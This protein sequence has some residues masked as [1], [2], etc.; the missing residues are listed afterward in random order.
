MT[1]VRAIIVDD[2]RLARERVRTL[3][4]NAGGVTI[5]AECAGGQEAVETIEAERPD[6]M[7]LDVQMPDLNGFEVLE[8]VGPD[9]LPAVVFV[10]AYDEYALRAFEV[11]A[12]DYLLK[13]IDPGRFAAALAHALEAVRARGQPQADRR[14][15]DLL[16]ALGER[17]QRLD[18]LVV[19]SQGK[20]FFLKP[21]EIDWIE[22][23]GKY[24]RLHVGREAHVVRYALKRLA[25]RLRDHGFVR[26]HRSAIVNA[27]RIKELQP[28]FHG[29]YVVILRDG[30]KLTS[31]AAHSEDL[32]RLV[33][34]T[35]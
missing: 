20:I 17:E 23:D 31:S 28:W 25:V 16:D 15:L 21:A 30:T 26:V 9:R 24:A 5:A 32:H 19:R 4:E 1:G 2:E 8:A 29:E 11:H 18:R 12:L 33:D 27:D 14:L 10:T 35:V 6:L 7:F 22:A 3:L 34:K 13:P